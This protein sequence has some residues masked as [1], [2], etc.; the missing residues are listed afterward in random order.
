MYIG[1][2]PA[3]EDVCALFGASIRVSSKF[4]FLPPLDVGV[5]WLTGRDAGLLGPGAG[6]VISFYYA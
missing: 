6:F 3:A 1:D 2:G 5:A 4:R